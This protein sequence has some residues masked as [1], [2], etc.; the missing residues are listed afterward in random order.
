[1]NKLTIEEKAERFDFL[2]NYFAA[3]MEGY[4]SEELEVK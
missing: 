3:F 4:N 1:M 2:I